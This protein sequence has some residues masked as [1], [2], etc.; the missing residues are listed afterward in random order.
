MFYDTRLIMTSPSLS[1]TV[2]P[3]ILR[4]NSRHGGMALCDL[5]CV[6][7]QLTARTNSHKSCGLT[8]QPNACNYP[9]PHDLGSPLL[10]ST[11][12]NVPPSAHAL[13]PMSA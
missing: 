11:R 10:P 4:M 9:L 6:L 13:L 5:I 8:M 12:V 2:A 7:F 3:T 1:P